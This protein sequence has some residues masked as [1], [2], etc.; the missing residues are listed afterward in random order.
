MAGGNGIGLHGGDGGAASWACT[1][2]G[3]PGQPYG[4]G[5]AGGGDTCGYNL[6]GGQP[7]AH[8]YVRI[9]WD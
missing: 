3:H 7:G 1:R 2:G 8:G 6:Y 9:E 4:G 5:G